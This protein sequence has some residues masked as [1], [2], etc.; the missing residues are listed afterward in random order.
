MMDESPI[1]Y[2]TIVVWEV[3][4]CS[5]MYNDAVQGGSNF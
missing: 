1:F 2:V 4:I 3:L 5:A